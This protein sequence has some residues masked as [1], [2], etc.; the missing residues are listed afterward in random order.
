MSTSTTGLRC[1]TRTGACFLSFRQ[2]IR[3]IF[4]RVIQEFHCLLSQFQPLDPRVDH[5]FPRTEILY[6]SHDSN[7]LVRS[8]DLTD[9]VCYRIIK[10]G[11][12]TID[13]E[14]IL[15]KS[16]VTWVKLGRMPQLNETSTTLSYRTVSSNRT[17]H[18][19]GPVEGRTFSP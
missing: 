13:I 15:K 7:E 5:G 2:N 1:H 19:R 16:R 18:R 6:S 4:C 8:F 11:C 12:L 9:T 10:R 3:I 17:L 14:G